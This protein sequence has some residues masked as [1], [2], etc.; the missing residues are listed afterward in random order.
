MKKVK[1]F[2]HMFYNSLIPH[3]RYY[4]HILRIPFATSLKY[5]LLLIVILNIVFT[6]SLITKY[7]PSQL[8]KTI[9]AGIASLR[10]Y[11]KYLTIFVG[12]GSLMTNLNQPFFFWMN[13]PNQNQLVA[14]IDEYAEPSKIKEY[15]SLL[16]FTR[17]DIVTQDSTT[18]E[19]TAIPYSSGSVQTIT[20][21]SIEKIV[22]LAE[23]V[24][25]LLP[26]LYLVAVIAALIALPT[27]SFITTMMYLLIS[28]LV[29]FLFYRFIVQK[30]FTLKRIIQI[31]FHAVTLPLCIDYILII[32]R[33][34]L[35]ISSASVYAITPPPFPVLFF[36]LV[37]IFIA[38]GVY[39]AH[40]D[41][42][43]MR[44]T[45]LHPHYHKAA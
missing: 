44:S 14:V 33:P 27:A 19:V 16:L 29:I 35:E 42:H 2:F 3:V 17:K 5:L 43:A 30:R 34:S 41:K 31:S 8:N 40:N 22:T 39:E 12:K 1:T 23:R 4:S 32:F 45:P 20:K 24:K 11:P 15:H 13:T 26:L 28:S 37:A 25:T 10:S 7:N 9:D 36:L 21:S 38:A 18:Q 6:G